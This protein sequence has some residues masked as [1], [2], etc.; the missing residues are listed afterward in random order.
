MKNKIYLLIGFGF[1]C[2]FCILMILLSFDVS[3][4]AKSGEPVGLSH[5]NNLM[6]Y[7]ENHTIDK[8]SDVLLYLSFAIIVIGAV[9]GI[10]QLVKRKSLY[11]VDIE[12]I[13]LGIFFVLSIIIWI[14]FDKFIKVNVRPIGS[15]DGSF[16]STHVLLTTF[17]L[18]SGHGL[19]CIYLDKKLYKYGSLVLAILLIIIVTIFRLVSGMHYI[20]D[21]LGG[22]L[23]GISFYFVVFGM[24]KLK[25]KK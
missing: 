19:C 13:F 14:V 1:F 18:L 4:I 6:Q 12:I 20:T 7:N 17:L 5:I 23:L 22:L 3:V 15:D 8:I 2:L 16:P 9:I 24:G 21:V 10:L 25:P 11:K